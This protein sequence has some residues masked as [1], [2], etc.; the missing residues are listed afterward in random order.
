MVGKDIYEKQ[1]MATP[2]MEIR[3]RTEWQ[4]KTAVGE[5]AFKAMAAGKRR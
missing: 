5:D 1:K 2:W 4:I 3:V